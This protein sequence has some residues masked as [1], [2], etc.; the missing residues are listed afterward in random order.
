MRQAARRAAEKEG[1]DAH[2]PRRSLHTRLSVDRAAA[3]VR[4]LV[5]ETVERDEQA[6]VRRE[7][8][9]ADR[10]PARGQAGQPWA[11][12]PPPRCPAAVAVAAGVAAAASCSSCPAASASGS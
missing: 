7:I 5:L 9:E 10:R 11:T 4:R 6:R 8:R 3:Q 12:P 1:M 2:L